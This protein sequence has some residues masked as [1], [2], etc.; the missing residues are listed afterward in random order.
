MPLE[1]SDNSEGGP[2]EID[3][4][5]VAQGAHGEFDFSGIFLHTQ[6]HTHTHTQA[7]GEFDFSGIFSGQS[8]CYLLY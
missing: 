4:E 2:D 1:L 7:H 6:I 5:G 3:P 8:S